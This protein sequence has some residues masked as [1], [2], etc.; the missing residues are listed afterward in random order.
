AWAMTT[1]GVVHRSSDGGKT[2]TYGASMA[3]G[4]A[5]QCDMQFV[6]ELH[7]FAHISYSDGEEEG[8]DAHGYKTNDGGVTWEEI[9]GLWDNDQL[10]TDATHALRRV[11]DL[12]EYTTNS[13]ATWVKH[14]DVAACRV[15][16]LP[17][18]NGDDGYLLGKCPAGTLVFHTHD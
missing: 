10:F 17:T 6:D 14:P 2:W 16:S 13:G 18:M 8:E 1:R 15:D 4:D 3:A 5:R 11:N 12:L 9:D 7:G